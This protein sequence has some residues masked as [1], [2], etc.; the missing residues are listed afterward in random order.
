MVDVELLTDHPA[1][2]HPSLVSIPVSAWSFQ[3]IKKNHQ[4]N[5]HIT[6]TEL[7]NGKKRY[8]HSAVNIEQAEESAQT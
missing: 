6:T 4:G 8:R 1:C 2:E 5:T 3:P 7:R